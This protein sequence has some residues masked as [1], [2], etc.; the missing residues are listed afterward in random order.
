MFIFSLSIHRQRTGIIKN[1]GHASYRNFFS[2]QKRFSAC[3]NKVT[4]NGKS[5]RRKDSTLEV[6]LKLGFIHLII[7]GVELH[8][9]PLSTGSAKLTIRLWYIADIVK[10]ETEKV[11]HFTVEDGTLKLR[12]FTF[13]AQT[14]FFETDRILRSINLPMNYKYLDIVR[15]YLSEKYTTEE[16]EFNKLDAAVFN[17]LEKLNSEI[18]K[19]TSTLRKYGFKRGCG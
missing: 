13:N 6:T 4:G 19:T 12:G 9:H 15:L 11:L 1:I 7:P 14:T 10:A 18:D 2:H 16:L 8:V 5:N 3:F 17:A